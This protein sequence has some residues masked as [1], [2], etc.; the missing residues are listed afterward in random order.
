MSFWTLGC[1]LTHIISLLNDRSKPLMT[2]KNII[3]TIVIV[4]CFSGAALVL[5][6]GLFKKSNLS[7]PASRGVLAPGISGEAAENPLPFGDNLKGEL[8]KVL[9][10]NNLQ[11]NI[12]SYPVVDAAVAGI[13]VTDLVKPLP[14]PRK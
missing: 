4:I 2:R 12:L 11:Y 14:P 13:P 9:N 3:Q 7:A 8:K 5:Y 10:R 1:P 6:N